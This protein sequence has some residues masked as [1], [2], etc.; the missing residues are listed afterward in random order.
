MQTAPTTTPLSSTTPAAAPVTAPATTTAQTHSADFQMFLKMLTAQMKNQDPMNPI[1]ST[2]YATQLATFSGVEQQVKTNELL[3]AL[4][5]QMGVSGMG[6]I[7]GW[8][9]MEARAPVMATYD[10]TRP[11]TVYPEAAKGA[12]KAM[13]VAYDSSGREVTRQEV[14]VTPGPVNWT[15]QTAIGGQVMP[16]LYSFKLESFAAGQPMGSAPVDCYARIVEARMG[17]DGPVLVTDGGSTIAP[18]D[19]HALRPG[20]L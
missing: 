5:G 10:G 15:G 8:V 4:T 18:K 12:D 3:T 19:V 6:Q 17:T 7:A 13:L 9:G 1:D 11:V 20:A 16:G 2:A 14:A